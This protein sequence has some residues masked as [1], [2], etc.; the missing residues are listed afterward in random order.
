V[1]A[2][3]GKHDRTHRDAQRLRGLPDSHRQRTLLRRKPSG[4][5]AAAGRDGTGGGHAAEEQKDPHRHHRMR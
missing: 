5:Q 4:H 3:L 2:K 1:L